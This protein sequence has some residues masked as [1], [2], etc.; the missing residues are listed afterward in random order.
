M[1]R[2]WWILPAVLLTPL[3]V[4]RC[5]SALTVPHT[6]QLSSL[7]APTVPSEASPGT[8]HYSNSTLGF[9]VDYPTGCEISHRAHGPCTNDPSR[10][11]DSVLF[12]MTDAYGNCYGLTVFRYWPAV[13]RTI[14]ETAEHNLRG[15]A[16]SSRDQIATR[17]CLA[18][19]GE[20][21][22]EVSY[23]PSPDASFRDRQMLVVHDGGEYWLVFWWGVPFQPD[24]MND[25]P[26]TSAA[27]ATFDMF[28]Q[29]F[30]FVPLAETP[31]PP[32][33]VPTAVPT[34][35]HT[36]APPSGP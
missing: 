25:L 5:G 20:P 17:C 31:T 27:Q 30:A 32:P 9:C 11:C 12:Q 18:V 1:T 24:G 2:A 22:M 16:P 7:E 35:T 26:A 6:T 23:P 3:F 34:P 21:A 28:L 8:V 13:G 29:T 33:P 15:L 4:A 14:T 36:P 10:L 19:G